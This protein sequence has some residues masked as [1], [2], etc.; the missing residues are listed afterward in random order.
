[1]DL[2]TAG[3]RVTLVERE[4]RPED[5]GHLPTELNDDLVVRVLRGQQAFG[6]WQPDARIQAG[7]HLMV[8]RP[9]PESGARTAFT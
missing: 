1:M 7:D 8:I 6:F 9:T 5:V 2:I 3:G 4:A